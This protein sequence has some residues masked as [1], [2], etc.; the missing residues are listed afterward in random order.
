MAHRTAV[1]ETRYIDT[2]LIDDTAL[3]DIVGDRLDEAN[4][5][6]VAAERIAAAAI[7]VRLKRSQLIQT[8]SRKADSQFA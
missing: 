2:A 5:I 4:V 6:D 7:A 8:E 3:D 1:R